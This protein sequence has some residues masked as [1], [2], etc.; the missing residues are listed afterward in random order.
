MGEFSTY[1]QE[2]R[3]I[4]SVCPECESVAR[5]PNL[6]LS[7]KGK[8]LPDWLDKIE[9][10][11]QRTEQDKFDLGQKAKSLREAARNE[12]EAELLPRRLREIA[13]AFAKTG[14]DPRDV[15]AILDPVQF[16][17]F[18]GMSSEDGV[19]KVVFFSMTTGGARLD[20]LGRAVKNRAY[21]WNLIR[22]ADDGCIT[23]SKKFASSRQNAR[24]DEFQDN[25]QTP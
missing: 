4:F 12:V 22:V 15:G 21:D 23:Q 24:L 17:V 18:E 5:I 20:S 25:S 6:E 14:Y 3:H 19:R 8:Y 9:A 13:P 7:R 16:V 11:I 2:S 10:G 1:I